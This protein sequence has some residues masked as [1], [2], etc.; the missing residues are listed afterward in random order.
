MI[1]SWYKNQPIF[2]YKK[3]IKADKFVQFVAFV[4]EANI[5]AYLQSGD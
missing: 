5:T 4:D 1:F 3:A 2:F